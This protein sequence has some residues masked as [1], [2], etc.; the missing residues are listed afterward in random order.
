MIVQPKKHFRQILSI[1]LALVIILVLGAYPSSTQISTQAVS[2]SRQ[3]QEVEN[4]KSKINESLNN[5]TTDLENAQ[6]LGNSLEEEIKNKDVE[7]KNTQLAVDD[8]NKL[9]QTLD[10]QIL[11]TQALRDETINNIKALFVGMQKQQSPFQTLLSSENLADALSKFYSTSVLQSKADNYRLQLEESTQR[12][13]ESKVEQ[14]DAKKKL[15][16]T[17]SLL[18]SQQSYLVDLKEKTQNDEARY[19]QLKNSFIEQNK[20]LEGKIAQIEEQRKQAEA[21]EAEARRKADEEA[22]RRAQSGGGSRPNSGSG[23]STGSVGSSSGCWFEDKRTLNVPNGYLSSPTNGFL[24]R[25]F[26]SCN[27]D[28]VDVANGTGTSLVAVAPGTVVRKGSYDVAGYGIYVVIKHILPSGQTIYT[29]YAHLNSSSPRQVGE[30][31]TR[32]QVVGSMG[33]TGECF[34]T[35]VHF[36]IYSDTYESNGPGCRLGSSKCYDPTKYIDF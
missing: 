27:H 33:C 35:H 36:M 12:L 15:E 10:A 4:Q 29:L 11:E 16:Q 20:Q 6:Q 18:A 21:A 7:I 23:G 34:G 28:A 31:V 19:Q 30:A 2:Y 25:G 22:R 24:V 5:I 3:R 32:G 13:E 14:L 17:Q 9:I 26:G 8:T 1:F